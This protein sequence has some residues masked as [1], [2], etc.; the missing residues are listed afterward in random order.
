MPLL[1]MKMFL[2]KKQDKEEELNKENWNFF[3][4]RKA[5][6]M[7]SLLRPETE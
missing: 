3:Q 1:L 4:S 7:F 5:S 2:I 6:S